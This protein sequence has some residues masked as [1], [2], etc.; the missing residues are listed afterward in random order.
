MRV[1][2]VVRDVAQGRPDTVRTA[3]PRLRRLSSADVRA[4]SY[5][6]EWSKIEVLGHVI[7]SASHQ[8]ATFAR[9]M[10]QPHP[11]IPGCSQNHWIDAQHC[12]R[13]DWQLLV[14]LFE[15][16]NEHLAHVIEHAPEHLLRHTITIE[17]VR[18]PAGP[19]TLEFFMRDY[20]E[21][22]QHHLPQSDAEMP[23]RSA[24]ENVYGA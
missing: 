22:I 14:R 15:S 1:P 3:V 6:P 9:N 18:G 17:G 13:A 20:I 12:L 2:G 23:H 8:H 7:D 10:Q 4:N 19:F 24:F 11:V 21:L 16:C 5:P